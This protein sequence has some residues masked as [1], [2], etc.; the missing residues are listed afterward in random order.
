M[1]FVTSVKTCLQK[2]AQ[3]EGRASLA[4]FWWFAL[5][6]LIVHVL[7]K[8]IFQPWIVALVTL[9]LFVPLIAAGS[10]RLHDIGKSGW[11]QLLWIIPIFGWMILLY[12]AAQPSGP[13][14][15]YGQPPVDGAPPMQR[16]E[17]A[18]GQQP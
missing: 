16:A 18:P 1:D 14:N 10:R 15:H 17:A 5:F 4:E 7:G 11:L 6:S 13:A 8:V 2:Y 12:W 9:A 3:F